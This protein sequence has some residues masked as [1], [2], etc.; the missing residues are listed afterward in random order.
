MFEFDVVKAE[1]IVIPS[2]RS[3]RTRRN[4][5]PQITT[6]MDGI[7][8]S[9]LRRRVKT[10][11]KAVDAE[12]QKSFGS[13][14]AINATIGV[15]RYTLERLAEGCTPEDA[16]RPLSNGLCPVSAET[17]RNLSESLAKKCQNEIADIKL[18][19]LKSMA[20]ARPLYVAYGDFWM[21]EPDE[22]DEED[23]FHDNDPVNGWRFCKKQAEL[24]AEQELAESA[25]DKEKAKQIQAQIVELNR[26]EA[27]RGNPLALFYLGVRYF[28]AG[29]VE[30]N[31]VLAFKLLQAAERMGVRRASSLLFTY[32]GG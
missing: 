4:R 23:A 20:G 18:L 13:D 25:R 29:G 27:A 30:K 8:K 28:N 15:L 26:Q 9:A 21:P 5:A 24:A 10:E 14:M 19:L 22:D 1:S 32:F 31:D 17:M 7:V 12:F 11:L 3:G 6:R 2:G 16:A